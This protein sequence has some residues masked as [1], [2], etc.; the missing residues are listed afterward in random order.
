MVYPMSKVRLY[1]SKSAI[2]PPIMFPKA[3]IK[4]ARVKIKPIR[5]LLIPKSRKKYWMYIIQSA[6]EETNIT[7]E[8]MIKER[9]LF[10]SAYYPEKFLRFLRDL[11]RKSRK[12]K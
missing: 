11:S 1:P 7:F 6:F 5:V 12:E 4:S 2:L 3:L 8:S 9:F 10:I